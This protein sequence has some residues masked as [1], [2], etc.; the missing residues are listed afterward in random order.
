M[1]DHV[2]SGTGGQLAHKITLATW[3]DSPGSRR[4]SQEWA[5]MPGAW[6]RGIDDEHRLVY[7]VTQAEI[8]ILATR[9]HY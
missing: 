7:I 8:I 4:V 9:Y 5:V 6:S 3:S 2:V 1:A